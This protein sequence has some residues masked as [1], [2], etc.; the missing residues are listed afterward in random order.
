[1]PSDFL[2]VFEVAALLEV[3]GDTA[4]SE[5]VAANVHWNIRGGTAPFDHLE[6]IVAGQRFQGPQVLLRGMRR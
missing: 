6:G 3:Q 5:G 2:G 4:A 1:M